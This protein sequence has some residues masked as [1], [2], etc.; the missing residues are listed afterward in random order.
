MMFQTEDITGLML[1]YLDIYESLIA[2]AIAN[3]KK[4]GFLST[5]CLEVVSNAE[6]LANNYFYEIKQLTYLFFKMFG[7]V[8]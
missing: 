1:A 2:K 8:L 6:R 7:L 3:F 4:D 5:K